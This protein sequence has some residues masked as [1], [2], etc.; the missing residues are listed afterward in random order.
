MMQSFAANASAADKKLLTSSAQRP[1]QTVDVPSGLFDF[2][3]KEGVLLCKAVTAKSSHSYSR[4]YEGFLSKKSKKTTS[5]YK[6]GY[7]VLF[8]DR[9]S[10]Y[11]VRTSPI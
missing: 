8:E 1:P 11:V 5:F 2:I 10:Y 6:T 4:I 3:N 7:F 9:L